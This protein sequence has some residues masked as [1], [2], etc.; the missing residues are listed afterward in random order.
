MYLN[1][2][3]EDMTNWQPTL[4]W[5]DA[6]KRAEII[7]DIRSFFSDRKVVEVETP[8][9]SAYGV[10]DVYLDTFTSEFEHSNSDNLDKSN[11]LHLQTS[12]EYAMKRLL[13]AGYNSIY[14]I[15]K[16]YRNEPS[17]R[18]HNPEFTMLE[19]YRLG[20]DQFMLMDEVESLLIAILKCESTVRFS[21]QEIFLKFVGIDPLAVELVQL[22]STLKDLNK[23]SG[24]LDNVTCK[25][26]LLQ[27][28]LTE[29]I[30][31]QIGLEVPCFVYNFPA[32][33]ASLSK[34]SPVDKRVAERFECYYKGIELVNG[35]NE[36]T[37]ATEQQKRFELDNLERQA[38]GKQ[39]AIIDHY[40]I[41]S[42]KSG[43]PACAGVALG[44]DRLIML[45]LD[46]KNISEVITF[47]INRA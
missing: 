30:E 12:P 47:D 43:L 11:K 22:V 24:W 29:V 18:L 40:F 20:F 7:K 28:I 21:Y 3:G 38:L 36:L 31:P 16:A 4:T 39:P 37:C 5:H 10:T 15:A 42:L 19:W 33:Q 34:I 6:I 2:I 13:A 23:W 17:G 32:S 45:A 9:L 44:V 14:Q 8:Q 27:V 41:Q 26:T 1:F 46:K 25:D 35:F